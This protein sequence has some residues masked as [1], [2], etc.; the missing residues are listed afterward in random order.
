VDPP[1]AE[2]G[3]CGIVVG[4][5]AWANGQRHVYIVADQSISGKPAVWGGSA[6]DAW[7]LYGADYLVAEKNFGGD[8][9]VS[10]LQTIEGGA[11]VP[12]EDIYASRGKKVRAGPVS[13]LYER[14]L[15]HHV[16][17][18]PDLED[19][20]CNWVPGSKMPSPNRLDAVVWVVWKLLLA[21]KQYKKAKAVP[22]V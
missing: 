1:G 14:G 11:M 9:V 22:Y 5:S 18:F 17:D 21:H 19:E 15:V 12:I 3:Q 6:M 13:S 20:L 10:T 2:S 4:G 16:G 7:D 8:M